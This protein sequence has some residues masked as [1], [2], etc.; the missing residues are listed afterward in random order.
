M[1]TNS[2]DD[3]SEREPRR[4][5]GGDRGGFSGGRDDRSG[6]QGR[7]NDRGGN[8]RDDSRPTSGGGGFRRDD[9]DRDRA[10]R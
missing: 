2:P 10:P 4:R 6:G 5:D 8:R 7:D 9:R 3:R 1:S